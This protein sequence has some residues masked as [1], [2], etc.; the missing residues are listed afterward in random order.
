MEGNKVQDLFEV[1]AHSV[2][3]GMWLGYDDGFVCLAGQGQRQGRE[4]E[5]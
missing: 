3:Y 4:K 5:Q 1:R 2:V